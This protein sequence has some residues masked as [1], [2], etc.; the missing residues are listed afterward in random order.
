MCVIVKL[1][2]VYKC[3]LN[4]GRV[5]VS[6]SLHASPD[7]ARAYPGFCSMKQLHVGVFLLPPGWDASPL[8][9]VHNR[10]IPR[11]FHLPP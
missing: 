4:H 11:T 6:S 8:L 10:V 5:E 9:L 1:T 3:F 2:T 7:Q